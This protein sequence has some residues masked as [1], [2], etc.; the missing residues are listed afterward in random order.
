MGG[1]DRMKVLHGAART[2]SDET[3][4][5]AAERLIG[6]SALPLSGIRRPAAAAGGILQD[7]KSCRLACLDVVSDELL[8]GTSFSGRLC[9]LAALDRTSSVEAWLALSLA[10]AAV[11]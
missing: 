9:T 4:S 8:S 11:L 1:A 3:A 7:G 10:R 6:D 2:A 5:F